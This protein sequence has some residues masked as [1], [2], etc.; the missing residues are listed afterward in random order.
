MDKLVSRFSRYAVIILSLF[1]RQK[2]NKLKKSDVLVSMLLCHKDLHLAIICLE[3]LFHESKLQF[4]LQILDDG[5]L[6]EIDRKVLYYFFD[7]EII[8]QIRLQKDLRS[9]KK[10]YP[11][12]YTFLTTTDNHSYKY[13]VF[14]LLKNLEKKFILLDSDILFL[15]K[16]NTILK[17]IKS[18]RNQILWSG[19]TKRYNAFCSTSIE[20][21]QTMKRLIYND[22]INNKKYDNVISSIVCFPIKTKITPGYIESYLAKFVRNGYLYFDYLEELTFTHIVLKE[23]SLQLHA[24]KYYTLVPG[25]EKLSIKNRIA[26][27]FPGTNKALMQITGIKRLIEIIF[28]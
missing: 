23:P 10:K 5:S 4:K 26:I 22:V 15:Q 1:L 16:P 21:I 19:L 6:T 11:S 14:L 13:K 7:V 12:I 8:S 25:F 27:H 20:P 2:N 28:L 3:T 18:D 24:E 17:W 9:Y